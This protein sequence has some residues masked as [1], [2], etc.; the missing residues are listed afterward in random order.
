MRCALAILAPLQVCNKHRAYP[1]KICPLRARCYRISADFI[2]IGEWWTRLA[3]FLS[4]LARGSNNIP[5]QKV[6][7]KY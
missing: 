7:R 2:V 1:L 3:I 5:G 6:Y 4:E